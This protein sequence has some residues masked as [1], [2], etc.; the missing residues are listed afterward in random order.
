M[1]NDMLDVLGKDGAAAYNTRA[2]APRVSVARSLL[3]NGHRAAFDVSMSSPAGDDIEPWAEQI[4]ATGALEIC[5]QRLQEQLDICRREC[6]T[7]RM[8][9]APHLALGQLS[10]EGDGRH[11]RAGGGGR[12]RVIKWLRAPT[13]PGWPQRR[14]VSSSA[15][16]G[17]RRRRSPPCHGPPC[18][19][20]RTPRPTWR[21]GTGF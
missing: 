7:C 2:G 4:A 8:A 15:V 16:V 12:G 6:A 19:L 10:G 14:A 13:A 18:D 1:S 5:A 20:G 21:P 17:G 3:V 11:P 9:C